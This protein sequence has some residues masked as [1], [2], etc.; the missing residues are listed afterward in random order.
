MLIFVTGASG[1]L[2]RYVVAEALARGLRVRAVVRNPSKA[3]DL[4]WVHD[5]RVEC[6]SVDLRSQRDLA[7]ALRGVDAV[8]HCAATKGGDFYAQAAGTVVA[9]ENLLAGLDAAGVKRFIAISTF[10]VYDSMGTRLGA[11]VDEN[12]KIDEAMIDRD[13]YA[14][15]KL[16]QERLVRAHA[17]RVQGQLTVIRPGMIYGPHN[18]FNAWVGLQAG[19]ALWIRTGG[20]AP[21]P[22]TYV[23]NCAE[24][25][26]LAAIEPKAI[27]ET[28]NIVDDETPTQRRYARELQKRSG[29]HPK[30]VPV[31]LFV[32]NAVA[33]AAWATNRYLLNGKAKIPGL[34][35]PPQL[36]ARAKPLRYSNAK[37]KRLLG[38]SPRYTLEAALDRALQL[39]AGASR[40][41]Q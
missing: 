9:T 39:E 20:F 12:A 27:G 21:I 2:G 19:P 31:P 3:A 30:I 11:L 35:V 32:L 4:P 17:E 38:W 7:S 23:E 41:A 22:L 14:K 18:L 28:I 15:T 24:A 26:V 1:F 16:L 37:A 8:I 40:A 5:A 25:I 36:A 13:G 10:S 34:F 33:H 6:V 29:A